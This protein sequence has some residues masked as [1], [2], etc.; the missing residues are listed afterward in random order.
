MNIVI[1]RW[2][3][4]PVG[5]GS[6]ICRDFVKKVCSVCE[7]QINSIPHSCGEG[8]RTVGVGSYHTA[9]PLPLAFAWRTPHAAV[10]PP[11]KFFSKWSPLTT[12]HTRRL[13]VLATPG[14]KSRDKQDAINSVV[15]WQLAHKHSV[16][17]VWRNSWH[18]PL[19]DLFVSRIQ[20]TKKLIF[21]LSASLSA[22]RPTQDRSVG[23]ITLCL[24]RCPIN[25]WCIHTKDRPAVSPPN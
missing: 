8:C 25:V 15:M 11:Q 16:N 18:P 4:S 19:W 3:S 5:R 9:S 21:Q 17:E 1:K 7:A 22:R 6:L 2:G 23:L 10:P 24:S 14:S 12:S 13:F 20:V